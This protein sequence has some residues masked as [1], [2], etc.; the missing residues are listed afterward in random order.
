[1]VKA[2]L[3]CENSGESSPASTLLSLP[4][5][6]TRPLSCP[7]LSIPIHAALPPQ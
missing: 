4:Y 3:K 2:L 6:P 5:V 1:M 7:V